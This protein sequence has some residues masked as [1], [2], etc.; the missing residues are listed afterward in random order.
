MYT[1]Q[2]VYKRRLMTKKSISILL[3]TI[4]VNMFVVLVFA[5]NPGYEENAWDLQNTVTFGTDLSEWSD[6]STVV[7]DG[8]ELLSTPGTY[9]QYASL[10]MKFKHDTN[11]L[12]VAIEKNSLFSNGNEFVLLF[13]VNHNGTLDKVSGDEDVAVQFN[14]GG[15]SGALTPTF[16][17]ITTS[18][19]DTPTVTYTVDADE[20]GTGWYAETIGSTQIEIKIPLA[21]IGMDGIGEI[22]GLGVMTCDKTQEKSNDGGGLIGWPKDKEID[23]PPSTSACPDLTVAGSTDNFAT[24]PTEWG[25]LIQSDEQYTGAE[26][27]A[28]RPLTDFDDNIWSYTYRGQEISDHETSHDPSHGGAAV[29]P[30]DVDIASDTLTSTPGGETSIEVSY[31]DPDSGTSCIANDTPSDDFLAFRLWTDGDPHFKTGFK[32]R[33][34]NVLL[35]VDGDGY[36]EFWFNLAGWYSQN[37]PDVIYLYYDDE[38]RQDLSEK[39]SLEYTF[40]ADTVDDDGDD[41][42]WNCT[43]SSYA[44]YRR[45]PYDGVDRDDGEGEADDDYSIFMQIPIKYLDLADDGQQNCSITSSDSIRA[46]YSTSASNT[47]PLQKDWMGDF[48]QQADGYSADQALCFGDAF[49]M[50]PDPEGAEFTL[51]P[52]EYD[53]T[54]GP[55]TVVTFPHTLHNLDSNASKNIYLYAYQ[56]TTD[57]DYQTC[58][59]PIRIYIDDNGD[60]Q[61]DAADDTE[62][63]AGGPVSLDKG[64]N[65]PADEL[66]FLVEVPAGSSDACRIDI[67]ASETA[68][69]GTA[70]YGDQS[71]VVYKQAD[72]SYN[73]LQTES[74]VKINEVM[75]DPSTGYE[76]VEITNTS[77]YYFMNVDDWTIS[78]GSS[79]TIDSSTLSGLNNMPPPDQCGDDEARLIFIFGDG[80]NTDVSDPCL[81]FIDVGSTDWFDD[82]A[83]DVSLCAGTS[84]DST[85]IV[86]YVAYGDHPGDSDSN[87]VAAGIWTNNAYADDVPTGHS[88]SRMRNPDWTDGYDNDLYTDW[89]DANA[90][91]PGEENT[92]NIVL[93][94][95]EFDETNGTV[96]V[97]W[98]ELYVVED[99][100]GGT[101]G[102]DISEYM[103]TDLDAG[104][105]S[106]FSYVAATATTPAYYPPV[107][108]GGGDYVIVHFNDSTTQDETD[109]YCLTNDCGNYLD[110][111]VSEAGPDPTADNQL[112]LA[113]KTSV[114]PDDTDSGQYIDAV[115]WDTGNDTWA[116]GEDSDMTRTDTA[117][118]GEQLGLAAYSINGLNVPMWTSSAAA[119][120]VSRE[121]MSDLSS[122]NPTMG[123]DALSTDGNISDDWQD[124]GGKNALNTTQGAQNVGVLINEVMFDPDTGNEWVEL[125]CGTSP[126]TF[127]T[128][129][130]HLEFASGTGSGTH[131]DI[132]SGS[133]TQD[134]TTGYYYYRVDLGATALLDNSSDGVVLCSGT[135]NSSTPCLT[136]LSVSDTI[137]D[138]VAYGAASTVAD[139]SSDP[140]VSSEHWT[141]NAFVATGGIAQGETIG[142][143]KN[144]TDT[145]SLTDWDMHGGPDAIGPTPTNAAGND[146]GARNIGQPGQLIF[147]EVMY[148]SSG[149]DWIEI[150]NP[151]DDAIDLDD[152]II[153][154]QDGT[155]TYTYTIDTTSTAID[156]IPAGEYLIIYFDD[157]GSGGSDDYSWGDGDHGELHIDLIGSGTAD[158][159]SSTAAMSLCYDD[160]SPQSC[161]STTIL[162]FVAWGS[163]SSQPDNSWDADAVTAGIWDDNEF[164]NIGTSGTDPIGTIDTD[165]SFGRDRNET[166][167]NQPADW[168]DH[169]GQD[170]NDI[171]PGDKNIGNKIIINEVSILESG[172]NTDWIELYN[173]TDE[174]QVVDLCV[175]SDGGASCDLFSG[176]IGLQP[177]T[178]YA[179]D[180]YYVISGLNLSNTSGAI[181]IY[182][183]TN[184][185][186]ATEPQPDET[187]I[188]DFIAYGT[189]PCA[190]ASYCSDADTAGIWDTSDSIPLTTIDTAGETFGRDAAS[191]DT[192]TSSD[193]A[194]TG[195]ADTN[196][197]ASESDNQAVTMGSQNLRNPEEP[198]PVV[199]PT[200]AVI[201]D[202]RVYPAKGKVIVEWETSSEVN[203]IGFYLKRLD[204]NSGEYVPVNKKL[205]PGLLNSPTGGTYRYVDR[206]A[207]LGETYTYQLIEVEVSGEKRHYGPF[208]VTVDEKVKR[209]DAV[210]PKTEYSREA[211]K[212]S[213]KE[214][215]RIKKAKFAR[216]RA[217]M[218]KK[219]RKGASAKISIVEPGLYYLDSLRLAEVM[220]L[221]SKDVQKLIR[222]NSLDLRNQGQ[223]V[224]WTADRKNAGIY[225]YGEELNSMYS[226]ENIYWLKSGKGLQMDVVQDKQPKSIGDNVMFTQTIHLEEEHRIATALFDDPL[227]DFWLWDYIIAGSSGLDSKTFTFSLDGVADTVDSALLFVR[228]LGLT[229]TEVVPDH[230]VRI[231]VN[232][233][234]VGD[235]YWDGQQSWEQVFQFDQNILHDGD[236]VLNI[237]GILDTGAPYS[238]VY[239]NSFDV[240]YQRYYR[241][242]TNKLLASAERNE[243]LTINGF[244][245]SDILV[246]DVTTPATPMLVKSTRIETAQDG[247]RVSFNTA[248]PDATYLAL[249]K[250]VVSTPAAIIADVPSGL[251]REQNGADYVV[252]T[253]F[254]L[255]EAA[256]ALADYRSAQGLRTIVVDIEDI[257]DEFNAG[258]ASPEAIRDFLSYTQCRWNL[259]PRYV[260]LAGE[261]TFDYKDNQGHGDNLIPVKMVG[262]PD[263]LFASDSWFVDIAGNDGIP[264]MAI[265]RLPFVTE[266]ELYA[267]VEKIKRY[268]STLHEAWRQHILLVA[269]NPDVENGNFPADSD[270]VSLLLPP[271][272]QTERIYLPNL[273]VN[274]ARQRLLTGINEGA[275]WMNYIGHGGMDRLS[276]KGLLTTSDLDGLSNSQRMPIVSAMTCLVGRFALPG[277]DSL[278]EQLV[279]KADGGAAAVWAPTGLSFNDEAIKLNKSLFRAVFEKG[280]YILGEVVLD[281][282]ESYAVQGNMP[283]MLSIYNLLGDPALRIGPGAYARKPNERSSWACSQWNSD[284]PK[285]EILHGGVVTIRKAGNGTGILITK[286]QECGIDCK[287][288]K[289]PY[290]ADGRMLLKAI[291]SGDSYFA[292][293]K[294][295]NGVRKKGNYYVQPG[296]VLIAVFKKK[297]NK[298]K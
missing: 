16:Y 47:D 268:E 270:A 20:T 165:E 72:D 66:E 184:L 31:Y 227:S 1:N 204:E 236:N 9:D 149:Y 282:L 208:V 177:G 205:L 119:D 219:F 28:P 169:G 297:T 214:T 260:V 173:P 116:S 49:T 265:G 266:E 188:M 73:V 234:L 64:S 178:T 93:N 298:Q 43:S 147:N 231:Y 120:A 113:T 242:A 5:H 138:F 87:A 171:T 110:L 295:R 172:T 101:A 286:T 77:P 39:T 249:T 225:F 81:Q 33:N 85:T 70:G 229:D 150:Y 261:G 99:G 61:F 34:W 74:A 183:T 158:D 176:T 13:D 287:V 27:P 84:C 2:G 156:S 198:P 106:A 193:W 216:Q 164:V 264:E 251:K 224:A 201:S 18:V 76:W 126:K 254:E 3:I 108:V 148:N 211:R 228:F 190:T 258:I 140:V 130:Y 112:A 133:C 136:D 105:Y 191:T 88:L 206:N 220:G 291:P 129:T 98:V 128:E 175:S 215:A 4:L 180:A 207:R 276:S 252:I 19:W 95:V 239:L 248:A 278:A 200:Y 259:P 102:V 26:D 40:H 109:T 143:D 237:V 45:E 57:P 14:P 168:D 32:S 103:L 82:D 170:A 197:L 243:V 222:T 42:T 181:S 217:D 280:E 38:D 89:Y 96:N 44:C 162:D 65:A 58:G 285:N 288:M 127:G 114:D 79:Y 189:S 121:A 12:Y 124:H 146:Y 262:T 48:C 230:H 155:S 275:L 37:G 29:Q 274:E 8:L 118:T 174:V 232:D 68:D 35:D 255:K 241:S 80:S 139:D 247:F 151:T 257:Y 296:D 78:D 186:D 246:F 100:I 240:T 185:T 94:E 17:N 92:P 60:G 167:T 153:K 131:V 253:T 245:E 179:D 134:G 267:F 90:P 212:A 55:G 30:T 293:W 283:F 69:S 281:A 75:Y 210:L 141:A 50:N 161:D 71:G 213:N 226:D 145:N 202:F 63:T 135:Y 56:D 263:G 192:N 15:G 67:L 91:S 97:D 86:D 272:Y 7:V 51:T 152:Y 250:G 221:T 10:N 6:A 273:S 187:T 24:S 199:G 182:S 132:T 36:K 144:Q 196:K 223:S 238:I 163:D 54:V 52:P 269:D 125:Y 292:G 111:Y 137:R 159:L 25:N 104:T 115:A 46:F 290:T 277:Y 279:L 107:T 194:D 122:S 294:D 284:E 53:F 123:R 62:I 195:G 11:Y 160:T 203:T 142:R 59:S 154:I 235:S 233:I 83:D 117:A 289:V 271:E 157:G 21:D 256:Q 244:T 22:V 41:T 218:R 209:R 23:F 166:D